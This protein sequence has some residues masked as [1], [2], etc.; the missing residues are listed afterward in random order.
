[1]RSILLFFI[2]DI[3]LAFNLD[4]AIA[5]AL[6]NSQK[7]REQ[8]LRTQIAQN[9]IHAQYGKFAP[10]LEFR[11]SSTQNNRVNA[12]TYILNLSDI[13]ASY[14]L[15]H[16]F[17]DFYTLKSYQALKQAQDHMQEAV[18]QDIILLTKK[19]YI[20]ILEARNNLAIA[21]ESV[22]LLKSQQ[23]QAQEFYSQGLKSKSDLLSVEVMLA[24]AKVNQSNNKN[25]LQHV[26]L[27]LQKLLNTQIDINTLEGLTIRNLS[28]LNFERDKLEQAMLKS[29]SEYLYMQS[30]LDS[31]RYEKR[32]Y[33][34]AYLP[35]VDASISRLW[36][37]N[38]VSTLNRL[39]TNLQ[40]QARINFT[41]NIFNGLNDKYL[42][43]SKELDILITQT[44]LLDLKY[45]LNLALDIAISDL[46]TAKEQYNTS[47][48]AVLLAEE[49]YKIVQN[50]Y[51]QNIETSREVLNSEIALSQARLHFNQSQ[52]RINLALA[53]LERIIQSSLNEIQ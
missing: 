43:E 48:K 37:S 46:Q 42:L 2:A 26:L 19:L 18:T 28:Q 11:Y 49:S 39:G 32:S 51:K 3:L 53:N 20:Q 13:H 29:R 40:S 6:Q 8:E 15:F 25:A 7:I 41:W 27:S 14:N 34:S 12:N 52:H 31:L 4:E 22:R 45:E 23:K 35:S 47:Q 33:Q 36:Y 38:D 30:V 16:G 21:T 1:M 10:K 24:N 17:K 9:N 5:L 50:R 44:R